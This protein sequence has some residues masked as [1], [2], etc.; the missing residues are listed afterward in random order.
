MGSMRYDNETVLEFA[1]EIQQTLTEQKASVVAEIRS[2][3]PPI[4]GC[5]VQFNHLLAQRTGLIRE[6]RRFDALIKPFLNRQ[7]TDFELG[8]LVH[9][10][11]MESAYLNRDSVNLSLNLD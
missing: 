11:V 5:D 6:I 4:A 10:F 2:Y 9:Q 7:H 1:Q 3:P 8:P